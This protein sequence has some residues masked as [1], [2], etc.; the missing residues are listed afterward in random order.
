MTLLWILGKQNNLV[1]R[2]ENGEKKIHPFWKTD[3]QKNGLIG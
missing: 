1:L 2:I 3:S